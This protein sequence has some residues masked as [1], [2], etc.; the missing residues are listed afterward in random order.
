MLKPTERE[1]IPGVVDVQPSL[2]PGDAL[3]VPHGD[4]VNPAIARPRAGRYAHAVATPGR[5]PAAHISVA[6]ARP[7][8][9]PPSS[10]AAS[11]KA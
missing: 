5:H 4:A 10:I 3:P 2:V 7:R 6:V 8:H 9:A 11:D 1:T